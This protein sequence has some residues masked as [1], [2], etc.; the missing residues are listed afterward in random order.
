M[1]LKT[2]FSFHPKFTIPFLF[3]FALIAFWS[4]K[5]NNFL[6]Q[7]HEVITKKVLSKD[8]PDF[9]SRLA[10]IK[11][12]FYANKLDQKLIP[13]VKQS[14]VWKPDWEHP[15]TQVVNDSVSYIFYRLKAYLKQDGKLLEAKEVGM[16]TY[17]MVKNEKEFFKA[18]YYHPVNVADKAQNSKTFSVENFTGNLLLKNLSNGKSFLLDYVN[19]T[20]S[21]SYSKRRLLAVNRQTIKRPDA[22]SY[23]ETQCHTELRSCLFASDSPGYC[24]G[25]QIVS[26]ETCQWPPSMCG[27][28]YS[29]IDSSEETIC[30][31]VWFPDPPA[32]P[33]ESGGSGG[34]GDGGEANSGVMSMPPPPESPITDMK[35]FLSCFDKSKSASLTVY[36]EKIANSFPGHAFISIK[37]GSNTMVF[38][39]YP[40]ETFPSTLSGPGVMGDNGQHAYN[41]ATNYGDISAEKLEKIIDT[42]IKFSSSNYTLTNN[43]CANFALEVLRIMGV[44]DMTGVC[45]P[46]NIYDLI[47]PFGTITNGKAPKTQRSCD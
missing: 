31:D 23:I 30:E 41:A 14:I 7:D 25:I 3:V 13:N 29:L 40:K 34:G 19:G 26:S 21:Q 20:V 33:G 27:V 6:Q 36:A 42:A 10:A 28:T 32:D 43:N 2:K 17:L 15:S 37:Q 46:D 9:S 11:E 35:K 47:K 12:K 39:F 22:T 18:F 44:T 8:S 38:G 1:I 4:C 16:A 45:T 24:S 5:K